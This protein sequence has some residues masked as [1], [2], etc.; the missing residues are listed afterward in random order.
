MLRRSRDIVLLSLLAAWAAFAAGGDAASKGKVLKDHGY[1]N[2]WNRL[3]AVRDLGKMNSKAAVEQLAEVLAD[4]TDAP[5]REAAVMELASL[6]D[7]DAIAFL[8]GT[9][10]PRSKDPLARANAAWALRL[11]KDKST[12][13]ALVTALGDP[14]AHVRACAAEAIGAMEDPSVA[15]KLIAK[16]GDSDAKVRAAVAGALGRLKD[17]SATEPLAKRMNDGSV[18]AVAAC[19]RALGEIDAL[20]ALPLLQEKLKS[21]EKEIKIAVVETLARIDPHSAVDAAKTL[22][23]D[24]DW[25]V[26]AATTMALIV[27]WDKGAIDVLVDR[28]QR[29]KGRLRFDEVTAL[30]KLT[31]KQIG[32]SPID[33]KSWWDANKAAFEMPERPKK[34]KKNGDDADAPPATQTSFFNIPLLS[35]RICFIID[36][37]GS[38][39]TVEDPKAQTTEGAQST[40]GMS[41]IEI[42]L[43][44]LEAS[45]NKLAPEV[46]FTVIMASTEATK[47][48]LRTISKKLIPATEANKKTA[49]QHVKD[50]WKKLQDIKRGRGDYYDAIM[51]AM[52]DEEVDTVF[53][54]ADGKPTYGLYCDEGNFVEFLGK[55]NEFRKV[56]IHCILT[57]KKGTSPRFMEDV[58]E[59]TGG[60]F[61]KR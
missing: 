45:I 33:W 43:K 3:D 20:K 36:F 54:V 51:E 17:P 15:D 44:E 28:L 11:L 4:P 58:S 48:K 14:D 35:D 32:F 56:M 1:G 57:G 42:A 53:L 37:S 24:E 41:K 29:E 50:A 9:L 61:V 40:E 34:G 46:K 7:K 2:F 16:L 19:L 27:T 52:E 22:I 39:K 31:G 30:R 13:P 25:S 60:M 55:E 47:Q 59:M 10:L 23:E 49:I 38:M 18:I 21:K 5:V 12:L 6:K 26:R 8:A